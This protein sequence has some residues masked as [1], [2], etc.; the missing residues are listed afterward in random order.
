MNWFLI[1]ELRVWGSITGRDEY[2]QRL[3][4][5]KGKTFSWNKVVQNII[6]C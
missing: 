1:T 6:F 3:M 4:M 5:N 2:E